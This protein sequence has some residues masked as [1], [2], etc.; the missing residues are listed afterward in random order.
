MPTKICKLTKLLAKTRWHD[1]F[2]TNLKSLR[3]AEP[4]EEQQFF[5]ANSS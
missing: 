2:K 3:E 1:H 5:L 4:L